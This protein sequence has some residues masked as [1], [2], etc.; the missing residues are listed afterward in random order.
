MI[1]SIKPLMDTQETQKKATIT[2]SKWSDPPP[3]VIPA[4]AEH[5]DRNVGVLRLLS[6]CKS[7]RLS[8]SSFPPSITFP[9]K[10]P[11][12]PST[13]L[14]SNNNLSLLQRTTYLFSPLSAATSDESFLLKVEQKENNP[15]TFSLINPL[16]SHE[17]SPF[18]P[19]T[20]IS[21]LDY[22]VTYVCNS[23]VVSPD[24]PNLFKKVV[25]SKNF[26]E[27]GD[28]VVLGL[29]C[30]GELLLWKIG[31]VGWT[32]IE[33]CNRRFDDIISFDGKFY[34]IA[35]KKGRLVMIDSRLKPTDIVPKLMYGN[36]EFASLI[37]CDGKLYVVDRQDDDQEVKFGVFKLDDKGRFWDYEPDL[38]GCVFLLGEDA[39]FSL[40]RK[41]YNG[42]VSD[43]IYFKDAV[44]DNDDML[45]GLSRVL[46]LKKSNA[47][48]LIGS[49]NFSNLLS[50]P[51]SWFGWHVA[52]DSR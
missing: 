12:P 50:P 26:F 18:F 28:F 40:S 5:L 1:G 32:K 10:L 52:D 14:S 4:I 24:S 42:I 23:Y 29:K 49:D 25:V 47:S 11:F 16:F 15:N 41:D 22:R 13:S 38:N 36:G 33:S 7:W 51:W 39:N 3:D 2:T 21:L 37:D 27:Y 44:V 17:K 6:V 9:L 19:K 8:L 48:Y 20:P 35:D 43:A 45:A 46:D 34:G 31:D 30:S